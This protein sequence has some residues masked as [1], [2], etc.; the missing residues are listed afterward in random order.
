MIIESGI[1][2]LQALCGSVSSDNPDGLWIVAMDENLRL[3]YVEPVVR[4]LSGPVEQHLDDIAE[5]LGSARDIAYFALGWTS[6]V[7]V[8]SESTWLADVDRRLHEDPGVAV[9]RLLGIIVFDRSSL[10]SSLPHCEFSIERGFQDLPRAMMVAGPHGLD[11]SCPPC[12]AERRAFDQSTDDSYG[13]GLYGDDPYGEDPYGGGAYGE[14]AY[15]DGAYGGGAYD[16]GG[17][18]GDDGYTPYADERFAD[19]PYVPTPGRRRSRRRRRPRLYD[20]DYEPPMALDGLQFDRFTNRWH[21]PP[22]RA[23]KR[24]TRD[25]EQTIA[26]SHE[27]GLSCF[28]I[29][30][31]VQRQPKAVAKRLNKLGLSSS[32]MV[33][34]F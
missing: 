31:L 25:E 6:A 18:Y 23:G 12:A 28:D 20:P 5:Y 19:G 16:S 8:D 3:L 15:G 27:Q 10:Y 24:W 21:P 1:D 29:S 11:C 14:G 34:S 7:E 22:A 32:T 26:L 30:L 2:V 17:S 13:D 9:S 4:Q 33:P